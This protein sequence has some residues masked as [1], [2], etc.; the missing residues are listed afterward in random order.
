MLISPIVSSDCGIENSK[1]ISGR[2]PL[3]K[4]HF[5]AFNSLPSTSMH[6]Y[7]TS[8]LLRSNLKETQYIT[9]ITSRHADGFTPQKILVIYELTPNRTN[10]TSDRLQITC[11][12]RLFL[13]I[14]YKQWIPNIQEHSSSHRMNRVYKIPTVKTQ[15]HT[16]NYFID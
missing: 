8:D 13:I 11:M 3:T 12:Y 6:T 1:S 7:I 9:Q 10:W 16:V 14:I 5:I 2:N 15:E 4:N